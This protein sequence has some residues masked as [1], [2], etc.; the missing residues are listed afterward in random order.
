MP[1]NAGV[2][3]VLAVGW[4]GAQRPDAN[5]RSGRSTP[6]IPASRTS[7]VRWPG[8]MRTRLSLGQR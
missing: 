8:M 3:L 7:S 5:G 1:A 4:R 2:A 6:P